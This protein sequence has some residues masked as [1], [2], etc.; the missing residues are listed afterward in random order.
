M[1]GRYISDLEPG[2]KL[3]PTEVIYS[4]FAAREYAHC[5]EMHQPFF[6][7]GGGEN[8]Y[9]P[10]TIIHTG[11]LK[12]FHQA[13][14]GGK[15][16]DARVHIEFDAEFIEPVPVNTKVILS[17]EVIDRYVKK[18]RTYIRT[19]IELRNAADGRLLVRYTDTNLLAIKP[20]EGGA[21]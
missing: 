18:N 11:K 16:P 12:L 2:D 6:H 17:G 10:P 20:K 8:H 5:N 9:A 7:A 13:C 21:A 4:A 15:G 1:L 3:G 19:N 14:P